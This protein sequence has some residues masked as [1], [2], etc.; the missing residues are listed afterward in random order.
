MKNIK[1]ILTSIFLFISICAYSANDDNYSLNIGFIN[2]VDFKN[3]YVIKIKCNTSED[4]ITPL[5]S[6]TNFRFVN[7]ID[8]AGYVDS[9]RVDGATFYVKFKRR[10]SAD[11]INGCLSFIFYTNV[12]ST[13]FQ[14]GTADLKYR[15]PSLSTIDPGEIEGSTKSHVEGERPATIR[16]LYNAIPLK[17]N[18][19]YSWEKKSAN[20]GWVEI[21]N[22]NSPIHTPDVIGKTPDSYRRKA[23]DS[24]GNY[25]YSN[26]VEIFPV[27]NAGRISLEYTD[28]G[29][30]LTLANSISPTLSQVTISWQSTTDLESWGTIP[31]TSLNLTTIKPSTTTYYRRVATSTNK[32]QYDNPILAYSNIVCYNT[33]TPAGIASKS[34]WSSDSAF[35][36]FEYV[37]GL[38]RKMQVMS[39]SA[40]M[41][42][43]DVVTAYRYDCNGR[44]YET[45]VP[46]CVVGEGNFAKNAFYKSKQ[47]H[48]DDF[49]STKQLYDNSPL[50]RPTESYKPGS[51][52]QS[53]SSKHSSITGYD[54]N[55]ENELMELSHTIG[56]FVV[57]APHK[58]AT[59]YKTTITD[60][61]GSM[62]TVFTNSLGKTILERR[63]VGDGQNA[64]TYFVYDA[65]ERLR[66]VVSPQG[67]TMLSLDTEYDNECALVKDYCY[68]YTYDNDDRV[69]MK[70]LPGSCA[71]YFQY[72]TNGRLTI[73]YDEEMLQNGVKKHIAYD[74]LG[75]E[76]G[77]RYA[78]DKGACCQQRNLYDVYDTNCS[79][80]SAIEGIV[81]K[82]DL[83]TST[84][85]KLTYDRTFEIFSEWASEV[86]E[87]TY[88]YDKRGRC[89]Q[90]ITSYPKG[91]DCRTSVKYDYA[92]NPLKTLEQYL[93]V[94]ENLE[95]LTECTYD[96]RGRKLTEQTSVNGIVVGH[97]AFS[98]D[99]QGR[100]T[101]TLLNEKI[102]VYADYNLQGWLT[103]RSGGVLIDKMI[104][105]KDLFYEKLSYYNPMDSLS[106]PRYTGK[107]SE[108]GWNRKLRLSG[109]D[110]FIYHYDDLGRL[111]SAE[112]RITGLNQSS[113]GICNEQ[114]TYDLAGNILSHN[115]YRDGVNRQLGYTYNG[116]HISTLTCDGT[117][118]GTAQY[119][120]RGNITK[121][122][123]ENLQIAYNL[124]NLPQSITASDGTK[125]NYGYLSDGTKFC[126]VS[127]GG[128]KFIYAGSLRLRIVGNSIVPESF[129]IAGGRV[130][131]NNGNWQTNYYITD[132]LGSVRT[133]TDADGNVLAEYDYTPYG[134]LLTATDITATGTDYLF[135]GKEQ[136][137]KLGVGELYDSHARFMN[138]TG[139][140]LSM[141]PLAEKY[142]HLSPYAYCAGDPVNLVDPD[143]RIWDTIWDIYSVASGVY[144]A[145]KNVI[146]GNYTEALQDAGG[147]ALD[148]VAAVIPGVPAVGG[149]ALKA[150]RT[151]DDV[152]DVAKT[153]DKGADIA[154]VAD[155]AV[156]AGKIGEKR[157]LQIKAEIGQEAHRQIEYDLMKNYNAKTEQTINIGKSK[158]R[159]DAVLPDGTLVII[160]PDTPTGHKAAL[161]REKL[162]HKYHYKTKTIFYNPNDS[163]FLSGSNTYI[164][165]KTNR[166]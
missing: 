149:A 28:A 13:A 70:R 73:C 52:Y 9:V 59:L 140:F 129:A 19:V 113:A 14:K 164:G 40:A 68:I 12:G 62:V 155:D 118:V 10:S 101:R 97:A 120:S 58:P 144:N 4:G 146:N 136:Q 158:V 92:G 33:G 127:D 100:I 124:C 49:A 165:P 154:K 104:V 45:T 159:K 135:T 139:S 121:I 5:L 35:I 102:A 51:V 79:S 162:M 133:V 93:G 72:D 119:D 107:I 80:F 48:N 60:E 67:S 71:Q 31:G 16:S 77:F 81:A 17:G 103:N 108:L 87:R 86:R 123:G 30:T 145:V 26:V 18:I 29:S 84:K 109:N 147:V 53:N 143:G 151:A 46:F 114:Y 148:V 152:I 69:V 161:K 63:S 83:A 90:T 6:N 23:T 130:V 76:I 27:I 99:E 125:V 126:A 88:Y 11:A 156:D 3:N 91:I 115:V 105:D 157:N 39:K 134:E 66:V 74:A 128:E 153:V 110:R 94:V 41:D 37:D 78:S 42:G 64:D 7:Y 111:T 122:P 131:C 55:G 112:H 137:G 36:D 2:N 38:G 24:Q 43:K 75:R 166:K 98:Y 32:D 95:I 142:Y 57:K 160:K 106:T 138:T 21:K 15:Y 54:V 85:G 61:D 132:Y 89:I 116:N 25:A 82:S 96:K 1:N 150:A 20:G 22:S 141:D 34:Y 65:K 44:E 47:F 50:N 117:T 163:R 56:G 8:D